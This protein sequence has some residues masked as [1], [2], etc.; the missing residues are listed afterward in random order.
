MAGTT[1][2]LS[3][4]CF[5]S[6]L[7]TWTAFSLWAQQHLSLGHQGLSSSSPFLDPPQSPASLYAVIRWLSGAFWQMLKIHPRKRRGRKKRRKRYCKMKNEKESRRKRVHVLIIFWIWA[8]FLTVSTGS[9]VCLVLRLPWVVPA[10]LALPFQDP[11]AW[12]RHPW[13]SPGCH[14]RYFWQM[15]KT[16]FSRRRSSYSHSCLNGR[17]CLKSKARSL[18]IF[19]MCIDCEKWPQTLSFSSRGAV[20]FSAPWIWDWPCD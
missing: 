10:I 7:R 11:W 1:Q 13:T 12:N 4:H 19:G 16:A 6:I 15:R 9:S 20:C 14:S 3:R 8:I 18:W 2:V 17:C 5:F